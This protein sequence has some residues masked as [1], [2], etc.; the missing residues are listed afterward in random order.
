MDGDGA[1]S[2]GTAEEVTTMKAPHIL[3][4]A[5][6]LA[7]AV[8]GNADVARA[9]NH[10]NCAWP[11]EVSPEGIANVVLPESFARDFIV[12]FDT[13]YDTMTIKGTY[14]KARYFSFV[15]YAGRTPTTIAGDLYDA[16]IAADPGS[17]NPF[18][19][20]GTT[21]SRTQTTRQPPSGVSGAYTVVVSRNGLPASGNTIQVARGDFVWVFLR[22]YVPSADRSLSGNS[23]IG[24]VPLPTISVTANGS[25][26]VLPQCAPINDMQDMTAFLGALFEG[27]ALQGSEGKPST[28][29]LWFA[30]PE[31]APVRLMPNPHNKYIAMLP[32]AEYQPGRIIVIHGKAP[33]TPD[34]YDGSTVWEPARTF[35][36]VDMRYWSLCNNNFALPI[37]VASCTADLTANVENGDYTIVISDDL[38]RP[39]WL[40]PG[41]N[42]LPWGDNQYPKLV[43]FRNML[44]S[45]D[46]PFSVQQAIDQGCTFNFNLP[47]IPASDDTQEAGQCVQ[48]VMGEYYPVAA[49]CDR[50]TFLRGGWRACIRE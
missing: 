36:T 25:S 42:W 43:F 5:G 39:D 45:A 38:L 19:R 8:L 4:L 44:S 22:M 32:G 6:L 26:Q 21:V 27:V 28:D 20:P 3:V 49:W 34:T 30:P 47:Y 29:R 16:Q 13:Q 18:V 37:P 7:L 15:V 1:A 40:K 41:I 10:R 11:I 31:E 33:G 48:G 14:P 23:L 2:V 50:E 17:V 9:Q 24:G 35:Q 12:P 46:F